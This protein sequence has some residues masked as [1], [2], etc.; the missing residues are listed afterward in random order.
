MPF[1]QI[2]DT[3]P[4]HER[5]L[6]EIFNVNRMTSDRTLHLPF[7]FLLILDLITPDQQKAMYSFLRSYFVQDDDASIATKVSFKFKPALKESKLID[8]F[9]FL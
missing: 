7:D 4:F 9:S 3:F 8:F 5:A 2:E 6:G 1:K